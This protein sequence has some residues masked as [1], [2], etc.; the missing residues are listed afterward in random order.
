GQEVG[1]PVFKDEPDMYVARRIVY[2]FKTKRG[3]I[4]DVVTQQGEGYIHAEVVK[5]NA[6][7]T[8]YGWH[9]RYTT[10]NLEHP[11][12][13]INAPKMKVIPNDRVVSGPFNLVVGDIPTPLGFVLGLFPMPKKRASGII[14]PRFGE[15]AQRGFFLQDGGFYWAV[16]DY[17]G[18]KI[19]GDIFSQG[20]YS[21]NLGTEYNNRYRFSGNTFIGYTFIP[22]SDDVVGNINPDNPA[23]SRESDRHEFKVI[24]N[25]QPRPKPGGGLFTANVNAGS[26]FY[27]RRAL[28]PTDRYLTNTFNSTV[29]YQKTIQNSPFS[30]TVALRQ[31][32]NIA[33]TYN[34]TLP[35]ASFSMTSQPVSRLF[36]LNSGSK[37]LQNFTVGYNTNLQYSFTNTFSGTA[38]SL[39]GFRVAN[40]RTDTTVSFRNNLPQILENG[41]FGVQH[42]IPINLGNFKMLKYLNVTP[43]VQYNENWYLKRLDYQRISEDSIR[44]DTLNRFSRT[45]NYAAGVSATTNIYGT[46]YVK[47]KKVEAIRHT[48]RPSVSY[49]YSPD[50]GDTRFDFYQNFTDATGRAQRFSR[51]NNFIFGGAPAAGLESRVS[52]GVN[53][54]VEMKVRSDKDT[55]DTFR[56]ISLLDQ[57][58]F[59]SSYNF[60]ADSFQM[61]LINLAARTTLFERINL[62]A[63]TTYDPYQLNSE[64]RRIDVYQFEKGGLNLARLTNAQFTLGMQLNNDARRQQD[65]PPP[66]NLP[67]LLPNPDPYV[68]VDFDIPW[69][70]TVQYNWAYNKFG[71]APATRT[72]SLDLNGTLR[73]TDKWK[74]GYFTGYD[75]ENK[76]VSFTRLNLHRD[77]HCWQMMLDWVPFGDLQSISFTISAKASILQDLKF[78]RYRRLNW[79]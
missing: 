48:I 50:F 62:F 5:K 63:S 75:F 30:Y 29:S 59:N 10:C 77:L 44:I 26:Q 28:V 21:V 57:L 33:G 39:S 31:S 18:A 38:S 51:Y 46:V 52:F 15:S 23:F 73:L 79:I 69:D 70:L 20:G 16:N 19:T 67:G 54:N 8:I 12:F 14:V 3:K 25:H 72:Q 61:S 58:S 42:R 27:D 49:S 65:L 22:A 11:H 56:K 53:N 78:N 55:T 71:L 74:L 47:G 66:S 35:D 2:N 37:F 36:G 41:I 34:F 32:Q 6:D 4:S 7:N 40:S 64:G 9:A 1:T 13:Y 17:I 24:W 60:A 68:Y 76:N 43:S 45:Y